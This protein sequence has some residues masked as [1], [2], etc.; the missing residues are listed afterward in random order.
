MVSNQIKRKGER[1]T[2]VVEFAIIGL[3]FFTTLFGI[4]EVG[5]L[6]YTH[7][8]LT[9][10]TRRAARYAVLHRPS[11]VNQ[12]KNVAVYGNPEGTGP[13]I[14]SDLTTNDV[15]VFYSTSPTY[16]VNFGNVT[17][18]IAEADPDNEGALVGSYTFNFVVPLIGISIPMPKYETKLPAESAGCDNLDDLANPCG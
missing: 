13:P 18:S 4:I 1:G 10:A 14:I 8:E 11:A 12:V 2:S 5:R 15:N 7:N 6:L 9:R 3:V 17:V 16:G